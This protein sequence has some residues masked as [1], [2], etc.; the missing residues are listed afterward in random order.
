MS[1]FSGQLPK[2]T[3]ANLV[4]IPGG[5]TASLVALQDGDGTT[6]PIQ[7]S[8]STVN[9]TGTFTINGN[10]VT[11]TIAAGK[12]LGSVSGSTAA[13]GEVTIGTNL[14]LSGGVL[15]NTVTHT[16]NTITKYSSG[17]GTYTPTSGMVKI[18]VRMCGAGGGGGG[19]S[20]AGVNGVGSGG[21]SGGYLEFWMSAAQ[22]GASKSYAV[23][24][25]GTGA[26]AGANSGVAGGNTTFADWTATGGGKGNGTAGSASTSVFGTVADATSANTAGTGTVILNLTGFTSSTPYVLFN[27]GGA[28]DTSGSGSFICPYGPTEG[29]HINTS[30]NGTAANANHYGVGG[31]GAIS[32][33][34]AANRSGG[35]GAGGVIIIEE[36]F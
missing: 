20:N 13:F 16:A 15:S 31:S 30:G 3:Y 36:F 25:A 23:G 18:R 32:F 1:S 4:Q 17:S 14:S 35:D 11:S 19:V 9:M 29:Q 2:A 12:L 27:S 5:V 24:A 28:A 8:S 26:T 34:S 6:I 7:I 21:S 22:V 33:N 10:A